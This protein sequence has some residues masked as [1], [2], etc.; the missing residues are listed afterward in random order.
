MI[1]FDKF[2]D[3]AKNRFGDDVIV[4]GNEIKINSIFTD[5]Y[6]HKL[7][8]NPLGGKYERPFGVFHCWKTDKRGS[9]IKLVMLV[10]QCDFDEAFRK[11]SNFNGSIKAIEN[12]LSNLDTQPENNI[13]AVNK[14][15]SLPPDSYWLKDLPS[16]NYWRKLAEAH[17]NPRKIEIDNFLICTKGKYAYRIIIPYYDINNQ[18]IYFNSRYIG[19]NVGVAKYMG[20]PKEAG[21]GKSD[22]IYFPEIPPKNSKIYITEGEFDAYV[23]RKSGLYSAALG[24]KVISEKQ[25]FTFYENKYVPVICLDNDS[26]GRTAYHQII[27]ILLPYKNPWLVKFPFNYKCKDWND[28][29][30]QVGPNVLREYLETVANPMDIKD[31]LEYLL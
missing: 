31:D 30:V 12:D 7:W 8:C 14:N 10:D 29:Y 18:L 22:V 20:P 1:S 4:N 21:V 24:G 9:L 3:W 17:L 28:L 11:L 23:I 25:F 16:N 26:A 5:D 6:K 15:I 27:N 19:K 2:L 13:A